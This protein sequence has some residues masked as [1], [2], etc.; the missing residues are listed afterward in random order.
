MAAHTSNLQE[1]KR[2]LLA[3]SE[4]YRQTLVADC[5]RLNAATSWI[6]SALRMARLVTPVI[7]MAVP[8]AGFLF[9]SRRKRVPVAPPKKNLLGKVI[10]GYKIARQVRPIWDGFRR[11][12]ASH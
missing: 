4:F 7:A 8:V 2:Q 5:A 1:R 9:G 6:S 11:A 12:R 3:E 10:A